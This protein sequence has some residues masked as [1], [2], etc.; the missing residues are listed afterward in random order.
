MY[1]KID[2]SRQKQLEM[3]RNEKDW[4]KIGGNDMEMNKTR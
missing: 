2:G 3:E 4:I 1:M